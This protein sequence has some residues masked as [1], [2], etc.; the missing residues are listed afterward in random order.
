MP[1]DIT[2]F[3][4]EEFAK[5][6][7]AAFGDDTVTPS[8]WE[9]SNSSLDLVPGD[10]V[11][12]GT[13][14][15]FVHNA[16]HDTGYY[17]FD[18]IDD[19]VSSWPTMPAVYTVVVALS[20]SYPDGQPYFQYC[21]DETI[22]TLLTTP[23]AYTG[24]VHNIMIFDWELSSLELLY[25]EQYQ[26]R[27]LWRDTVVDPFTARL[28]RSDECSL[29]LYLDEAIDTFFD[30]SNNAIGSTDYSTVWDNGVTF[31]VSGAAFVMD[32]DSALNLDALT[33]FFE[34][35]NFDTEATSETILQNGTN[36]A[37]SIA[38][39]TGTCTVTLNGSSVSFPATGHRTFA[40]SVSDGESPLCYVDGTYIDYGDSAATVSSAGA[41]QLTIGNNTARNNPFSST[42][43]KLSIY[44][45]VLSD[46][47]I[48]AAHI[49]SRQER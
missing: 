46:A 42:L 24:N 49:M 38:T 7:F 26:L 39:S 4:N 35:P 45:A 9:R 2:N 36:Y 31:P 20:T 32:A 28:I 25:S 41:S 27:R 34:A 12:P 23:G 19:Y 8:I 17:T 14:P 6:A 44:S 13:F 37:L 40:V 18:G 30:Y 33:I 11:T 43:K 47:E 10:G 15:T 22:K 16:D 21:N 29:C 5:Y 1:L 48:R 3:I